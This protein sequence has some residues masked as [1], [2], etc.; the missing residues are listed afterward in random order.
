M[1]IYAMSN[2][3]F[4][5]RTLVYYT[6]A[7]SEHNQWGLFDQR[8]CMAGHSKWMNIKHTKGAKD[9]QKATA[10]SKQSALIRLAIRDNN[11]NSN[12]KT[13]TALARAIEQAK[14]NMMPVATIERVLANANKIQENAKQFQL[15]YRGPGGTFLLVDLLTDNISRSKTFINT[16]IKKNRITEIGKGSA[17]YFFQEKGVITVD[18]STSTDLDAAMEHAIEVG[19]EDVTQEEEFFVFTCAPFDFVKVKQELESL[20]YNVIYSNVD[21]VPPNPVTLNLDDEKELEIIIQKLEN[22]DDV[23]KVYPNVQ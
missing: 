4:V 7:C 20:K 1:K 19:A 6:R 14:G 18:I 13:N 17:L 22:L 11:N 12:P 16:A 2:Y 3:T 15:E 8:R 10:I 5:R 21:M 23:S 9:G